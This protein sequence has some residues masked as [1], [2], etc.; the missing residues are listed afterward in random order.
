MTATL[1]E[2]FGTVTATVTR[3]LSSIAVTPGTFSIVEGGTKQFVATATYSDNSTAVVTTS[4]AWTTSNAG[5]ATVGAATG[6]ATGSDVSVDGTATIT[7]TLSGKV[8]SAVLTVTAIL[9][10]RTMTSTRS[11]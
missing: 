3:S 1:G 4:C 6:L 10:G 11:C 8:S 5:N 7:A 9:R 2:I